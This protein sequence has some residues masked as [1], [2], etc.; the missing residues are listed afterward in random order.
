MAVEN[1]SVELY[2][3]VGP[4][5]YMIEVKGKPRY[6]QIEHLRLHDSRSISSTGPLNIQGVW[7]LEQLQLDFLQLQRN[8]LQWVHQRHQLIPPNVKTLKLLPR[9]SMQ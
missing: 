3:E 5:N 1:G 8:Q 6:V 2:T 9:T 7:K 4:V